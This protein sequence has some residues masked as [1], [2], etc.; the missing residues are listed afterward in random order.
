MYD[1]LIIHSQHEPSFFAMNEVTA[2]MKQ[3]KPEIAMNL[4]ILKIR[5]KITLSTDFLF[6][7]FFFF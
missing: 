6:F 5:V 4:I 2:D 1:I 7:F 3:G